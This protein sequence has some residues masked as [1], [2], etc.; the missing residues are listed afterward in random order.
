MKDYIWNPW[1][2]CIK[3]SEGCRNCYVYRRDTSVGRDAS[4]ITRT[5]SFGYPLARDRR[6]TY[7]IPP[8]AR[9]FCCMTS[10]FFLDIA[11]PWR[12]E[13]WDI[14][15]ARPD[16][17]FTI[18][19]KRISRFLQCIPPDWGEGWPHV[20]VC[21]TVENQAAADSRLPVFLSLPIREKSIICEP[22]LSPIHMEKW[23]G[24][25]I[26]QVVVGGESGLEARPCDY[27]WVLDI[28]RQCMEAGVSF[29]FK[30]TGARLIKDGRLYRI[31]RRHQHSQARCAGIDYMKNNPPVS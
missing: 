24:P 28:R 6:G 7:K 25:D 15:R 17:H 12:R 23:L 29:W 8:G 21:C 1:H 31:P 5:K 10:D 13:A 30:Q 9:V 16:V 27:S 19:T 2:G 26:T 11:D 3:W 18:I 20:A 22:L 4:Q 14:I